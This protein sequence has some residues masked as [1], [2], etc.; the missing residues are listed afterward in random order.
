MEKEG[1]YIAAGAWSS[2]L[3]TYTLSYLQACSGSQY[4]VKA[5]Y[6]N[7]KVC[8]FILLHSSQ[9]TLLNPSAMGC[10]TFE[11]YIYILRRMHACMQVGSF[12]GAIVHLAVVIRS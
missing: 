9:K 8:F 6:A 1:T 5:S 3:G 2:L 7:G 11:S 10:N 4:I 12:D